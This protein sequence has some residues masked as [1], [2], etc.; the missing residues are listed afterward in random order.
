MGNCISTCREHPGMLLHPNSE[1][2]DII[3]EV[4]NISKKLDEVLLRSQRFASGANLSAIGVAVTSDDAI[5]TPAGTNSRNPSVKSCRAS[6]K[7][8]GGDVRSSSD[9]IQDVPIDDVRI[10]TARQ[11]NF[12]HPARQRLVNSAPASNIRDLG[13]T[14]GGN[15]PIS[16]LPRPITASSLNKPLPGYPSNDPV[17]AYIARDKMRIREAFGKLAPEKNFEVEI[18]R[19][20]KALEEALKYLAISEGDADVDLP[21][22][23]EGNDTKL[24]KDTDVNNEGSKAAEGGSKGNGIHEGPSMVIEILRQR[25]LNVVELQEELQQQKE[26]TGS[27]QHTSHTPSPLGQFVTPA[28]TPTENHIDTPIVNSDIAIP[29]PRRVKTNLSPFDSAGQ[30]RLTVP[31]RRRPTGASGLDTPTRPHPRPTAIYLPGNERDWVDRELERMSMESRAASQ[32]DTRDSYLQSSGTEDNIQSPHAMALVI[33]TRNYQEARP[34][35]LAK[36]R[37]FIPGER[38]VANVTEFILGLDDETIDSLVNDEDSLDRL[39]QIVG[40]CCSKS[41]LVYTG[42]IT[43][44]LRQQFD[45]QA[46]NTKE[47]KAEA[48]VEKWAGGADASKKEKAMGKGKEKVKHE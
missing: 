37:R 18:I 2:N 34:V 40:A 16:S 31:G 45:N 32:S 44:G 46:Q 38:T 11:V 39:Q 27:H 8:G 9:F 14:S 41:E 36:V 47:R 17:A 21:T 23:G 1:V 30:P 5:Q 20:R 42:P 29:G 43:P 22:Q 24:I 25:L 12:S 19:F 4:A 26:Q 33:T 3:V 13:S 48:L 15:V 7:S 28:D 35:I 10:E 6:N